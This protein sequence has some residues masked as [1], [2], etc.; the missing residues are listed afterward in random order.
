MTQTCLLV[1][2]GAAIRS[3]D[4]AKTRGKMRQQRLLQRKGASPLFNQSSPDLPGQFSAIHL[5][6]KDLLSGWRVAL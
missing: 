3:S 2:A 1:M 4:V 6:W 5:P